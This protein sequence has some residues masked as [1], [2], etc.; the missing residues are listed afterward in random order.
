MRSILHVSDVHFGPPHRPELSESLLGLIESRRPDLVVVAGDLTQRA[1]PRQFRQ[2]R[3]WVDRMAAPSLAV[4]GNHDVPMYRFWERLLA[5]FGAYSRHFASELEPAFSDPEL[6]VV[7]VNS[8]YNWTIKDG[9]IARRRLRRLEK[10]FAQAPPETCRIAV[11]HHELIPAP[12]FG[13]R[14]VLTNAHATVAALVRSGVE[15]VLSGH[16][17]Q[18]YVGRGEEYYPGSGALFPIVHSGTT[19]SSRGR[20]CE[21]G[22]CTGSWVRI[23]EGRIE[24]ARLLWRDG[25]FQ[26]ERRLE[27]PRRA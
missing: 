20:G 17:H 26:P 15:L 2:A 4:P 10:Q 21:R 12:R 27:F 22:L 18:W 11:I 14:K 24:V 8:A 16:L 7:G 19:T 3:E 25:G 9:R 23:E 13:S 1:K 6:F 5:P